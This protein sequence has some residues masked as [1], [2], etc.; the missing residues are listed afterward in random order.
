LK[1][2]P[3]AQVQP[4]LLLAF[5][6]GGV[7]LQRATPDGA[8]TSYPVDPAQVQQAFARAPVCSPILPANVLCWARVRGGDAFAWWRPPATEKLLVEVD[9]ITHAWSV[10]LP[11]L[12]VVCADQRLGLAAVKRKTRPEAATPVFSAPF[13]NTG[14]VSNGGFHSRGDVCLGSA[15]LPKSIGP[16]SFDAVWRAYIGSTFNS[17]MAEGKSASHPDDVRTLLL[18]LHEQG[19]A[20]F[21]E[22]ELVAEAAIRL[23]EFIASW[24]RPD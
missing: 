2:A 24:L 22:Q 15:R 21:P 23:E 14:T 9:N 19:G 4:R 7:V 10:P 11:G 13:P 5:Y 20:V 8:T 16:D 18:D 17:H 1:D 6:D 12:V 3:A